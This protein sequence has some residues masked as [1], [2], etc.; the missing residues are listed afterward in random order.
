MKMWSTYSRS[1]RNAAWLWRF[2]LPL[3]S[4][5]RWRMTD[6][7]K[8]NATDSKPTR[9]QLVQAVNRSFLKWGNRRFFIPNRLSRNAR[10]SQFYFPSLNRVWEKRL[11]GV[12]TILSSLSHC[13]RCLNLTPLWYPSAFTF[14]RCYCCSSIL[15][16]STWIGLRCEY[17]LKIFHSI[18]QKHTRWLASSFWMHQ[19]PFPVHNNVLQSLL[20]VHTE[21]VVW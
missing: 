8:M 20:H 9:P 18:Q 4:Y 3:V 11:T 19:H 1:A 13:Y 16:V 5:I 7:D 10:S 2:C 14:I 12:A 17:T 21:L 15:L 6:V